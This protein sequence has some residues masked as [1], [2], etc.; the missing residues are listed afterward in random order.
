MKRVKI[1]SSGMYVPK[2][3]MTN[4][5]LEKI[6]GRDINEYVS[7]K[8]GIR[9]RY[10]ADVEETSAS[11]AVEAAKNALKKANWSPDELDL[12]IVS[13]DTP[14]YLSPSTAAK[15][16]YLLGA[17][18]AG[19][20]D[21]NSACSGFVIA[22]DVA[23]KHIIIDNNINKVLIIGT[24]NMSKFIDWKDKKT[25]SIFADGAAAF[26]L[27]GVPYNGHYGRLS[28]K[29]LGKGEYYDYMGIYAGGTSQL[30]TKEILDD[31]NST[32]KVR[33][34]KKF[35]PEINIEFWPKLINEALKEANINKNQVKHYF[36]TQINYNAIR[37]VM[38]ELN[39]PFEKATTIMDK[40]GYTGSA[41]IPMAF[42]EYSR[43]NSL[44]EN[45]IYVFCASGGGL[46][47]C[48]FV[49]KH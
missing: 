21:I 22:L 34:V 9:E 7:N 31:P 42:D 11:M 28:S 19:F 14:E 49:Y 45:D 35:G 5:D 33:F 4:E 46:S 1:I 24:Y 39:E 37:I 32:Y 6:I 41:C 43:K 3:K 30:V 47:M 16:Q 48:V 8:I 27:E 17:K 38:N 20:F 18:N 26:L 12:I 40:Y 23:S 2:N 13:T 29:Y 25:A 36:F 10:F 44:N 15:V